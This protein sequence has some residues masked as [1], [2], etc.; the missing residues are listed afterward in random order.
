MKVKPVG[1]PGLGQEG[2]ANGAASC[3]ACL[4]EAVEALVVLVTHKKGAWAGENF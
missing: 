1:F 4:A 3:D 2:F